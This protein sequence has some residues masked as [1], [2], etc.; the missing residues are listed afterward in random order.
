MFC[1]KCGAQMQESDKF[2]P[3]CGAPN[4]KM[5]RLG[6]EPSQASVAAGQTAAGATQQAPTNGQAAY[7]AGFPQAG[8]PGFPTKGCLSQ[9]FDDITKVPGA[10]QRV[11]QIAFLPG[12]IAV[13]SVIALIVPVIGWVVCPIGLL[14]SAAAG[15]CANGYAI[16]WGRELS[17]GRG[18]D[19]GGSILKTSLFSLGFFSGSLSSIIGL[20]AFVP[21]LIGYLVVIFG[22]GAGVLFIASGYQGSYYSSQLGALL[23]LG[24]I[25]FFVLVLVTVVLSIL[26][27]MFS[28][29]AV[30]HLAVTGRVES[31]FALGKVWKPFKQQMGALFCA[32]ILPGIIVGVVVAIIDLILFAI[33][34]G[35]FAS[36]YRNTLYGDSLGTF[37]SLVPLLVVVAAIVFVS[38]C[39]GAFASVLKYRAVGYWAQRHASDWTHEGDEDY[40][41]TLSGAGLGPSTD[42]VR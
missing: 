39:S 31:A 38:C 2:C 40:T 17:R 5:A 42:T 29:A 36:W 9:A 26:L 13:V 18:F 20:L 27:S 24:I 21:L 11:L 22:G 1:S 30:M 7:G 28:D 23:G 12:V 37:I 3:A 19:R 34:G 41:F 25:L 10:F 14:L 32:S 35:I 8:A 4:A 16:E 33:A 6:Q 15:I